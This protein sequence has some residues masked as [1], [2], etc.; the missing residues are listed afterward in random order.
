[1]LGLRHGEHRVGLGIGAPVSRV[2]P[3]PARQHLQQ[4]RLY[5]GKCPLDGLLAPHRQLHLIRAIGTA[6]CG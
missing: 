1:V 3:A 6:G 2:D 4:Q 5:P